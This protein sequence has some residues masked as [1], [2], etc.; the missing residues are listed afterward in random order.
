MAYA[1]A[2]GVHT[3]Y[4]EYGSGRPLLLLHG[5]TEPFRLNLG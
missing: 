1:D 4:A 5:A 3:W 2:G